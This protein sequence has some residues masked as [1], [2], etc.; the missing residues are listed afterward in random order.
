MRFDENADL[1]TSGVDDLRGSGGGGG[2]LGGGIG[3]R[4]AMGGGGLGVVGIVIYLLLST[5]AGGNLGGID[6]GGGFGG[7]DGLSAGQTA[8]SGQLAQ[9]CRTGASANSSTDCEVVAVLNSLDSYWASQ[10]RQGQFQRPR[11]NFFD[12]QVS[13]SGC[14]GATSATGP[15]YCPADS[16]IYIDLSF[17]QELTSRFGT[18][19]GPFAQAYVIAHEYGHHIQNLT[20]AN[21]RAGNDTGPTSGSVRLELQA[22]CYAG[23]WANHATT[24]PGSSGRPLITDINEADI[25]AALDTASKIGDDYIQTNLGN[26]RVDESSFSHGSSAQRERWF[27]TGI[28]SGDPARCDTFSAR[29][30]G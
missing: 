20:G 19:G 17:F 23:V 18:Q 2:G 28:Q 25:D 10:F 11:T 4:V 22:D 14:G 12:G 21:R 7:L 16:E 3:G 5:F 8:D 27:T 1:D 29:D 13:T 24:T 30:L 6:A 26:G 15:F 9:N